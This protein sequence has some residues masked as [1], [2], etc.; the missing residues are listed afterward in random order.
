VELWFN[1]GKGPS[2]SIGTL[3]VSMY[4]GRCVK[5]LIFLPFG[6]AEMAEAAAFLFF[7]YFRKG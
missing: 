6:V 4:L 1:S 2:A 3:A 5:T 7:P